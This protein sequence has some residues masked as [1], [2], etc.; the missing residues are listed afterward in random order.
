MIE[1]INGHVQYIEDQYIAVGTYGVG[2]QVYVPN[3]YRHQEEEE[4][5]LY[6]HQVVREDAQLLF[7]FQTKDERDLFRLLLEVSGIGPKAAL[8]MIASGSPRDLVVAIQMDN[9][10]FLTKIPGIGKKTAQRIILD[11]KDKLTKAG[12]ERRFLTGQQLESSISQS[13]QTDLREVIDGLVGLGYNEEE[14]QMFVQAVQKQS[15]D[16][17]FSVEEWIKLALKESMKV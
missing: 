1:F 9:V 4:I 2:Y 15:Q 7:G 11:L 12:F 8:A 3:P 6:T 5:F 14:A 17:E 13:K 10:R 16:Q